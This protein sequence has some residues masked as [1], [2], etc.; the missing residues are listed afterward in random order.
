MG[1][2]LHRHRGLTP[3]L[4]L[5]PGVLW[6]GIFFLVPLAFLGYESLQSGLFPNFQFTWEFSNFSNGISDYH[7]QLIRSLQYAGIATV[8][9]LLLAYPLAAY[10][11]RM[12]ARPS[13]QAAGALPT[14]S[15]SNFTP[16]VR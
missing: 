11:A 13:V 7:E 9:C 4:L 10:M 12:G 14:A 2:F 3:Y 16:A 1:G 15:T 6:L 5:A 8:A